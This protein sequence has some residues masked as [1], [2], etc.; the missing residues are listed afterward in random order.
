MPVAY[1]HVFPYSRRPG[2]SA[3]AMTGQIPE[4]EKKDR[5]ERL[6]RI[7][8]EKRRLF[9]ER[10]IGT[11]LD[12]LIEGRTDPL[13]GFSLGF[14]DNYLP[15]AVNGAREANRIVRVMP[16]SFRSGRLIAEAINNSD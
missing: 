7:G 1:L 9:A 16:K 3:A 14:S 5:A 4:Q 2:T 15:V 10:F 8:G 13:S 12:V 11:P 6:R